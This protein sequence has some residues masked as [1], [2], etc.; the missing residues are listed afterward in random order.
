[1]WTDRNI[2][3]YET[4][5][6]VDNDSDQQQHKSTAAQSH[7]AAPPPASHLKVIVKQ[8]TKVL[9]SSTEESSMSVEWTVVDEETDVSKRLRNARHQRQFGAICPA[10]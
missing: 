8:S 6:K 1:V 9:A 5:K 7:S 3:Q 2:A 10:Q 4:S